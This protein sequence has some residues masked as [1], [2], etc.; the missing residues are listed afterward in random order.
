MKAKYP[1]MVWEVM[2]ATKMSYPDGHFDVVLDKGTL[3]ALISGKNFDICEAMLQDCMRVTNPEGQLIQI[4]YGS[5]EGRRKIFEGALPFDEYDYYQC[6]AELN[7]MSTMINLMRSN[8]PGKN[9]KN[10]IKEQDAMMKTLKEFSMIKL[11]RRKR[12]NQ[13]EFIIWN[14]HAQE[15]LEINTSH[16]QPVKPE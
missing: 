9:L 13:K 2:D 1:H 6:R 10:I 7:D 12:R 11:M 8:I 15:K 16:L 5:P 3:D 4:T 14:Q